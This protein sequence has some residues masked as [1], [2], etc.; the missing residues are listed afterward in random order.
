MDHRKN[1]RAKVYTFERHCGATLY[2]IDS[3]WPGI[4]T[5]NATKKRS[6][7][8]TDLGKRLLLLSPCPVYYRDCLT[9]YHRGYSGEGIRPGSFTGT[10]FCSL[11]SRVVLLSYRDHVV[12]LGVA[13]FSLFSLSLRLGDRDGMIRDHITLQGGSKVYLTVR[14]INRLVDIT[15]IL[16]GRI[17]FFS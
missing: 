4:V 12:L 1:S 13:C 11:V 8:L 14:V 6:Y 17:L 15:L 7:C 5:N 3:T 2:N 10:F 9:R 16:H